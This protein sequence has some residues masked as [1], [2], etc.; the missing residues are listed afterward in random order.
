MFMDEF[1]KQVREIKIYRNP[2]LY[3]EDLLL[4]VSKHNYITDNNIF[5]INNK[6]IILFKYDKNYELFYYKHKIF[7]KLYTH[8]N[9]KNIDDIDYLIKMLAEKILKIKIFNIFKISADDDY[10][11]LVE[12]SIKLQKNRSNV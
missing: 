5:Y 12:L 6:N 1:D 4:N 11:R 10:I 7:D 3:I 8:Y 2:R 9:I